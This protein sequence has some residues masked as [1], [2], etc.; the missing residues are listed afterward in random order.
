MQSLMLHG[1]GAADSD[2]N[3]VCNDWL[4]C[5][6]LVPDFG[7]VSEAAWQPGHA[8]QTSHL[9]DSAVRYE[10]GL[11]PMHFLRRRAP[12]SSGVSSSC[13]GRL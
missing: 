4:I 3:L 5:R 9:S 2:N 1:L 11:Q 10:G 6:G 13:N 7:T 8:M 12:G